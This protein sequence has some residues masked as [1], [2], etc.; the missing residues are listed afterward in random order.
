[1]ERGGIHPHCDRKSPETLDYK[2]VIVLPLTKRVRKRLK[3]KGLNDG[4]RNYGEAREGDLGIG[5]GLELGT[6]QLSV[7]K[8][9]RE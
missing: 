8:H 7:N 6:S 5:L 1:V 4:D 2:M 9:E 3:A